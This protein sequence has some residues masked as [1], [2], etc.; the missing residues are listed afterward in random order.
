VATQVLDYHRA[1]VLAQQC[2]WDAAAA[3]LRPLRPHFGALPDG[4]VA[5]NLLLAAN[6]P[7]EY[8]HH[9]R[10]GLSL[11]LT[12][13]PG[14]ETEASLRRALDLGGNAPDALAA[15]V[16]YLGRTG[17]PQKALALLREVGPKLSP[18]QAAQVLPQGYET[19]GRL[20]LAA[21][22][23]E[24]LLAARPASAAVLRPAADFHLRRR[25]FA[26]A[27]PLLRRLL[28]P[29]VRAPEADLAWARRELA[30]VLS[31][32]DAYPQLQ[33]ALRLLDLERAAGREAD[34]DQLTRAGVLARLPGR[35]QDAVRLLE[36]LRAHDSLPPAG[37]WVLVQLYEAEGDWAGAWQRLAALLAIPGGKT[38]D[39]L[40]YAVRGLLKEGDVI[41][42]QPLLAELQQREPDT[43]RTAVLRASLCQARGERAAAVKLL[44]PFADR[45]DGDC[46]LVAAALEELGLVEAA[47]ALLARQVQATG[48][49]EAL[50]ARARFLGRQYRLGEALELC[51]WA[52]PVA[53]AERA[54]PVYLALL[55]TA[56]ATPKHYRRVELLL[57]TAL[58]HSPRAVPLLLALAEIRDLQ[59]RYPEAAARYRQILSQQPDHLLALNN[60]AWLLAWQ[61][62]KTDE[63]LGLIERAIEL[64]G[65][66]AALL[67]TRGVIHLQAGRLEAATR[68]LQQAAA[69]EPT[70]ARLFHLARAQS[71]SGNP[72]TAARTLDRARA[73]R[74]T[75]GSLHAL[76]RP[77]YEQLLKSLKRL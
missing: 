59:G 37:W 35:R 25:R 54:A 10:L 16:D 17:K 38:P 64:A 50:L 18:E 31:L 75:P 36:Q 65:P 33:E 23:Y 26:R 14:P 51:E 32:S 72:T 68:D 9:L 43:F 57:L 63:A 53:G 15:L 66:Q 40:A 42:A 55:Q 69:Q 62:G 30:C 21:E 12:A 20:E 77:G 41:R 34:R 5:G 24:A 29:E 39:T 76:D 11:W 49:P 7:R 74:L 2:R 58:R 70:P 60:G 27:A 44:Q 56:G 48:H 61:K 8:R 52:W 3:L 6:A 13:G 19:L 46:G 67:D 47:D 1:R 45:P 22:R 71:L 28:A 73:L 4:A